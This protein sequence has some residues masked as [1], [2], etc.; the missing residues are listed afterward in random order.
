MGPPSFAEPHRDSHEHYFE[1]LI[2]GCHLDDPQGS[3]CFPPPFTVHIGQLGIMRCRPP[4]HTAWHGADPVRQSDVEAW[5][6]AQ[7]GDAA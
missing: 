2:P 1:R 5:L 7:S 3:C 6:L 4:V